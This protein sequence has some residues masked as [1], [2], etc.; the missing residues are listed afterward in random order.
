MSADAWSVCPRCLA[1]EP[2]LE[3]CRFREEYGIYGAETGTVTVE[4]SG[5]CQRCGLVLKFTD[6]HPIP[7]PVEENKPTGFVLR[8][9]WGEVPAGWFVRPPN[10]TDWWEVLAR[11]GDTFTLR[12]PGG[13]EGTWPRNPAEGVMVRKGTS[14]KARDDAL[15]ALNAAGFSTHIIEDQVS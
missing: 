7:M 15:A 8:K 2:G 6:L 12:G 4:Y 9:T 5:E 10:A 3:E 1:R 14:T 11:E 13:R